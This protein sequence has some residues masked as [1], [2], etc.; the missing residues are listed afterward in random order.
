MSIEMCFG[1]TPCRVLRAP[2]RLLCLPL[3]E[4]FEPPVSEAQVAALTERVGDMLG[5]THLTPRVYRLAPQQWLIA[6]YHGQVRKFRA[7]TYEDGQLGAVTYTPRQAAIII[8][9]T[10]HRLFYVSASNRRHVVALLPALNGTLFPQRP[11]GMPF[12]SYRFDLDVL[13][14]LRQCDRSPTVGVYPWQ[15]LSL[16]FVSWQEAGRN[17][18]VSKTDWPTNGFDYL[19]EQAFTWPRH[20]VDVGLTFQPEGVRKSFSVDFVHQAGLLRTTLSEQTFSCVAG[21]VSLCTHCGAD[22]EVVE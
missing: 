14:V 16:K 15:Q 1:D 12:F 2:R 17:A 13:G 22:K 9:D 11:A 20:L 21:L 4:P 5:I 3:P 10:Q 19:D 6:F 8:V 18:P 7:A